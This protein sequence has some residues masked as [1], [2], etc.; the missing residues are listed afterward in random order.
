LGYVGSSLG[1]GLEND[2]D[3]AKERSLHHEI[4]WQTQPPKAVAAVVAVDVD[5]VVRIEAFE[6]DRKGIADD[7]PSF[8]SAAVDM[9]V[10]VAVV[11]TVAA[12]VA[13]TMA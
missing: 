10:A 13:L 11:V 6:A 3:Q 4:L 8:A 12:V 5:V 1:L 7:P 2:Y 9:A